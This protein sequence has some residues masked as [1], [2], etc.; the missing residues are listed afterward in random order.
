[1][2]KPM[3]GSV[4]SWEGDF[5]INGT[6]TPIAIKTMPHLFLWRYDLRGGSGGT[7]IGFS[8]ENGDMI[9]AP[10]PQDRGTQPIYSGHTVIVNDDKSADILV[11]YKVQGNGGWQMVEQ[12]NY[13]GNGITLQSTTMNGGKPD[14]LWFRQNEEANHAVEGTG[15]PQPARQS[16]HR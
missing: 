7:A 2:A 11:F 8:R 12:Y 16:P 10:T 5:L 4:Q 14:F 15:D 9:R 13:T 3:P 6:N 1:M